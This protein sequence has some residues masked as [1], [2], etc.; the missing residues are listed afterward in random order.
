MDGKYL[1]KNSTYV[2]VDA[3]RGG[4]Q[5]TGAA[6]SIPAEKFILTKNLIT[7]PTLGASVQSHKVNSKK[8]RNVCTQYI[9]YHI[10]KRF[11]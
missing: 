2:E 6:L 3:W 1:K 11:V 5:R 10:Y 7:P 9:L 8:K 4:A